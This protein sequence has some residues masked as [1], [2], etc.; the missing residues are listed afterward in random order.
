VAEIGSYSAAE[1]KIMRNLLLAA[2]LAVA[3]CSSPA[4]D[5]A[6]APTAEAEYDLAAQRAKFATIRMEPDTSFLNAE[7][8]T[9]VNL[10]IE[11]ADLMSAIYLRQAYHQNP[12]LRAAIAAGDDPR[13]PLLL[14]MFDLHFGVWDGLEEQ[15]PFF[16]TTPLPD[17]AGFY[18]ADLD[19]AEFD[20][21]LA[22]HPDE[23]AQL[24]S[25]YT[26]VKRQGDRLVAVP[27]SQE[28]RQWLAPAA[29]LLR[30][31]AATTSN[32]S[33]KK[34]LSLRADAFLNDQYFQSELAWMDVDGTPI[35][36]AI[37]PYEVY[38]DRLY[39]TKTAFE[40]FVTVRDPRQ[41]ADLARYKDY[42]RDMEAN[43]PVEERF[44]NFQRGFSSPILVAN[45]VRGGGDN[46]PGVQTIAFN[47]PNDEKVR[48]AKGAKKVI[49]ANVL[50]AKY[51]RILAPMASLVLVP[52][53]APLVTKKYMTMETLFHELSHSLG[54]G[55]IT[56]GGRK[57]TVDKE[58]KEQNS[59]MEEGK[60]DVMGVWNI[61]YLSRRGEFPAAERPQL[62][63]TYFTG[64]FRAVRF[65]ID[66]A[67]GRGAAAQYGY[68]KEKGAFAWDSGAKRFRIDDARLERGLRDL[69]A[70][71]VRL[72]ATGDYEGA[73]AFL[74]R[75]AKLDAEAEAVLATMN[76]IAVDIQPIYPKRV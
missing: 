59:A 70:E 38:S 45:Q 66:E 11:A 3:A 9:V 55:S 6:A 1:V 8:R 49:L 7:E 4:T 37:G 28:Y 47:L 32:P 21:Y 18:P 71:I 64:I 41:S 73:K 31:A 74:N 62:L 75:Y 15:R 56:V 29:E 69:L 17:G 30:K 33:L 10:L 34:F 22:A 48:E 13:K 40:A 43:L 39:G 72:Q 52:E 12:Q 44:K 67:H 5:N 42:L 53:Q 61:L 26:V 76:A 50:G 16:G 54:P 51:D 24:L 25:P 14:E 65:G 27:Y 2:A 19:R 68:L 60:A 46:V 20:A 58:L 36:V 57:T 35:E 63:A 23:R